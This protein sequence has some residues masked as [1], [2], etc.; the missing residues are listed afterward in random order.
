VRQQF[1]SKE[2]DVETGL[3]Y[4]GA[5]YFANN[6]GRFIS[7]D[8][9]LGSGRAT[10]PQ[11]WNKYSYV[12]NNPLRLVDPDGMEDQAAQQVVDIGKD[13]VIN[14]KI[15]EIKKAAKPLKPGEKPVPTSVVYIPGEQTEL[16][17]ATVIGPDGEQLTPKP[18]NGYM[19]PVGLA[20]LDQGGNIIKA[21][22]D[23]FVV[24][25]ITADS[26]DAKDEQDAGR[27]R[28]SSN[29]EKGQASNGVFYDVQ[30]RGLGPNSGT[31]DIW[32]TQDLT[33]RQY[34]GPSIQDRKD[35]FKIQGIKIHMNDAQ[36]R[37]TITP[38]KPTK[39]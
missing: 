29:D 12:L 35:I 21:P 16:K 15:E 31:L 18:M 6:Q 24:E 14:K 23:M 5:R 19:Q 22:D 3:D 37:I 33:V 39:L 27:L 26:P 1:T 36:K 32:T 38:G 28:T 20:V 8:P 9:F 25:T 2:R 4:F 7:V 11:S 34:F 13:Q 17:N 30:T 10:M